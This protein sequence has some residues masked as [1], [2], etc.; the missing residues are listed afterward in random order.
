MDAVFSPIRVILLQ[1]AER[2]DEVLLSDI[3]CGSLW[4]LVYIYIHCIATW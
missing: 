1:R 3:V 2:K 4:N